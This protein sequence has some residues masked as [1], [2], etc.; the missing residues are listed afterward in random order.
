MYSAFGKWMRYL[1]P[2]ES[3][4]GKALGIKDIHDS[5]NLP[6]PDI[7]LKRA[8]FSSAWLL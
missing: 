7:F 1:E 2:A 8:I 5:W 6:G 3:S 4:E